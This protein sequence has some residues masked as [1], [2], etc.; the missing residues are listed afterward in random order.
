MEH[1]RL[2]LLLLTASISWLLALPSLVKADYYAEIASFAVLPDT[3]SITSFGRLE[4]SDDQELGK[5]VGLTLGRAFTSSWLLEGQWLYSDSTAEGSVAG[6]GFPMQVNQQL[7]ANAAFIAILRDFSLGGSDSKWSLRLGAAMGMVRVRNK[8]VISS[9]A[10][11]TRA[12]DTDSAG[13]WQLEVRA[14]YAFNDRWKSGLTIRYLNVADLSFA[15]QGVTQVLRD[16]RALLIGP[17]LQ[18]AF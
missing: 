3:T 8:A 14:E 7:E 15:S 18:V 13:A 1:R 6:M 5:G 11:L 2:T 9:P 16:T 17:Y 12:A 10:G 4:Y